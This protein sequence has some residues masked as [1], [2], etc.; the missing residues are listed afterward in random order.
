MNSNYYMINPLASNFENQP[1]VVLH[2]NLQSSK[3]QLTNQY[4]DEPVHLKFASCEGK[5]RIYVVR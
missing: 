4:K 3:F 2:Y 5:V 1:A